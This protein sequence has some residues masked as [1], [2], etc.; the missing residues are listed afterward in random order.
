MGQP[1]FTGTETLLQGDDVAGDCEM[2]ED[3][4]GGCDT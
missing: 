3:N 4:T 1:S 2:V